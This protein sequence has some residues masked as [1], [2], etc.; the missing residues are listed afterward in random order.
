MPILPSSNSLL[1]I[2][3][4]CSLTAISSSDDLRSS[5][6]TSFRS[7]DEAFLAAASEMLTDF[8]LT[9]EVEEALGV[10]LD[11]AAGAAEAAGAKLDGTESDRS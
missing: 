6:A 1:M 2:T 5:S 11:A 10:A 7:I 9:T 3:E 4:M 8:P